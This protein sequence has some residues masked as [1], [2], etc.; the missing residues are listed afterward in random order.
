M[1]RIPLIF[2]FCCFLIYKL[3]AI[4][5]Q[6]DYWAL[7]I[8]LIPISI[9]ILNLTLRKKIK[10]KSW[11]NSKF[12]LL[13]ER[14]LFHFES[15]ISS[16]LLI[17]KLQEVVAETPFTLFDIDNKNKSLLFGTN[18]NFLTWGENMYIELKDLPNGNTQ[19]NFTA[20]SLF[21]SSS[22]NQNQQHYQSFIASFEASLTI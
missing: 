21:G 4:Y 1:N 16:D 14:K 8:F 3:I 6:I 18:V 11:F 10:Y 12:N 13:L 19:V 5:F 20:I 9:L 15:E 22:W 17:E 2:T 7:L